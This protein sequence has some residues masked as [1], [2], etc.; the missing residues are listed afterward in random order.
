MTDLSRQQDLL[1][2]DDIATLIDRW[3]DLE[4]KGEQFPVPFDMAWQIAGYSTKGNGKR[5]LTNK[6]SNLVEYSDYIIRSDKSSLDGR[7]SDLIL[8]TCDAF[9]HFCLIAETE[10]GRLI[11]QYFIEAEK[12]WRLVQQSKP[13]IAAEVEVLAMK[14]EIAKQEAI[15]K[16]AEER[17]IALRHIVVTTMPEPIQQKI[18]G[19]QVIEKVEYRDRVIKDDEIIRDGST[20]NKTQLCNRYGLTTRNGKPDYKR[21]NAILDKMPDRYFVKTS[22]VMDNREF[23]REHLTELDEVFFDIRDRQLF[24]G[25]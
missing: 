14:L 24:L 7:S 4:Q 12:K 25:E 23:N 13:E 10:Q 5:K 18:L 17:T 11:R 19:Y 16:Q 22:F 15:A 20:I 8:F 1:V 9:K 21:L 3:I 2:S 6:K